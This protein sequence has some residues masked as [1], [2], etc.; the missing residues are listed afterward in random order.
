MR[1]ASVASDPFHEIYYLNASPGGRPETS[2]LPFVRVAVEGLPPDL[3][4]LLVTSDLQGVAPIAARGGAAGLLGEAVVEALV[5]LEEQ[6]EVPALG[7][8][9]AIVAGDL[10]S[11]ATAR[12]R[13]ASGD[14]REVWQA[15]ARA[16][17]W[18]AGV[19]G[20]HDHFGETQGERAAFQRQPGIHLL[21]GDVVELDGLRVG[22]VSGIIGNREKPKQRDE[23]AFLDLLDGVLDET[24]HVLVLH[25]GPDGGQANLQGNPAIR[26]ALAKARD[27]L[28]VCGHVHWDAPPRRAGPRRTDPERRSIP[29]TPRRR[30]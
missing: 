17:R 21:D 25:E 18:A 20:N 11:E 27:L 8:M 4:G 29:S 2:R 3:G 15:L 23:R 9:G 30:R 22:G 13:G 1:V 5:T 7:G 24:P 10:F 6:G 16:F 19:G 26:Q 28:V 12:K 14:V